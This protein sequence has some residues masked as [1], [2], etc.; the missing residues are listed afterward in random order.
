MP[1]KREGKMSKYVW[2][3]GCMLSRPASVRRRGDRRVFA[4]EAR[5]IPSRHLEIIKL[6]IDWKL[7]IEN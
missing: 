5:H 4:A 1:L 6:V 7:V 3:R 2:M